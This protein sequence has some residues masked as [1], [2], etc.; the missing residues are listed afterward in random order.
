MSLID[1]YIKNK[2]FNSNMGISVSEE[3]LLFNMKYINLFDLTD[4][5][6]GLKTENLPLYIPTSH[7]GGSNLWVI[8]PVDLYQGKCLKICGTAEKIEKKIKK[9]FSGI[10]LSY[11]DSDDEKEES[12]GVGLDRPEK[13]ISEDFQIN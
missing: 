1:E 2:K 9:F 10:D 4:Y 5:S 11:K 3:G 6:S 13:K 7:I 8:K 12:P